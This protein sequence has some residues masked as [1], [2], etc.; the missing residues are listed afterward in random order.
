MENQESLLMWET[1][2][3]PKRSIWLSLGSVLLWWAALYLISFIIKPLTQHDSSQSH[4]TYMMYYYLSVLVF[5]L[6]W[7]LVCIP[8]F[9]KIDFKTIP[10]YLNFLG[11]KGSVKGYIFALIFLVISIIQLLLLPSHLRSPLSELIWSI[12][13][14]IVEEIIFRG[15]I[16]GI[17]LKNFSKPFSIT[18]SLL[19]FISIH[20]LNGPVGML[21]AAIFGLILIG[22]RLHTRSILP[23]IVVHYF[24][25]EQIIVL[26]LPI[27]LYCLFIIIDFFRRRMKDTKATLSR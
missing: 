4:N 1:R 19:L 21:S 16:L 3:T 2:L 27:T 17:L 13:P 26:A 7:Y 25:N 11:I 6:I 18:L 24:V 10:S 14:A 5:F 22:M 23:G 9:L 12:Q 15:F 8:K 20:L